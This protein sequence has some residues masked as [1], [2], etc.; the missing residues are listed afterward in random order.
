MILTSGLATVIFVLSCICGFQFRRTWKAE[1]P[2]WQLWTFGV[3]A[4]A[5]LLTL[6]FVPLTVT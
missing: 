4:A 1:G 3:L 6:S 2:Q 5:G